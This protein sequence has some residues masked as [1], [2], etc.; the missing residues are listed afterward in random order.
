MNTINLRTISEIVDN[1]LGYPLWHP[2][3]DINKQY[4]QMLNLVKGMGTYL[5]DVD[6]KMYLDATSGL[7]NISLGY[8]NKNI[9]D[10]IKTQLEQLPFCSLFE[11]TSPVLIMAANK[12]LNLLN[13][14]M[15]KILFTCSGSESIDLSIKVMRKYWHLQE[16]PNKNIIISFK[17]SY[18]GT[19]YGS[20]SVS[21]IEQDNLK[22]YGPTL[23]NFVFH[24]YA[25]CKNC[26]YGLDCNECNMQCITSIQS[27]L[28]LNSD[29]IAGI[30]I[31]PILASNGVTLFPDGY[32]ARISDLC[33][34]HNVLLAVDEVAL[35]FYRTGSVFYYQ[36]AKM[37]PD[38]ICMGKGIN[39]GYLPLGAVAFN[40]KI[41]S[42]FSNSNEQI[43]HG[44]TQAGNL[45]SCAAC[46]T[47]IDQYLS[48]NIS[49]NVLETGSYIKEQLTSRL[50]F[51]RNIGDIRGV[52]L[53]IG[54]D[55][56]KYKNSCEY[57]PGEKIFYIQEYLKY[58]GLIIYRSD[59]GLMLLP[60][61]IIDKSEADIIINKIVEAFH[62]IL[63]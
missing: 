44:S 29:K 16:K 34:K 58:H 37:N 46:I 45:L 41:Y 24:E 3:S 18:H 43:I 14:E 1:K 49:H 22:G 27:Y 11:N 56:V 7:W 61:L 10:A 42:A 63:F 20:I 9:I 35:G 31:E 4:G 21:G 50:S 40:F 19:Y 47:T 33:K 57:L 23:A 60:M 59:T 51:H 52:G 6:N 38:I 5:F 30:L 15:E 62:I 25:T 55:L 39:S 8:G 32:L 17:N 2:Y 13:G 28:E 54:I 48:T 36:Y 53:L 26:K 12:I